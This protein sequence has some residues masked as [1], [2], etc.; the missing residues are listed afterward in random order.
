MIQTWTVHSTSMDGLHRNFL[1]MPNC[2]STL[3]PTSFNCFSPSVY[4]PVHAGRCRADQQIWKGRD[5]SLSL[6][7]PVSLADSVGALFTWSELCLVAQLCPT[8]CD[9]MDVRLLHGIL[10]A[11]ILEWVA[12]PSSRDWTQVSLIASGFFTVWATK[13]AQLGVGWG[14]KKEGKSHSTLQELLSC[15]SNG[16]LI[17][18]FP[19]VLL[20]WPESRVGGFDHVKSSFV[21]LLVLTEGGCV[22]VIRVWFFATLWTVACQAPLSMGFPRQEYW[23]GCHF[24]LPGIFDTQELNPYLLRLLHCRQILYPVW[25]TREAGLKEYLLQM[26]R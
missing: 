25:A 26:F 22:C 4:L 16:S 24:L 7:T 23:V 19:C 17:L 11:R 13:E 2:R 9:P 20:I 14:N 6:V 15:G 18:L 1:A 10:Q 5:R 8:L 3:Q 21:Q 12:M